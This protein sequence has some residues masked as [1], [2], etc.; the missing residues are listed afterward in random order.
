MARKPP[1]VIGHDDAD[2]LA[3][4]L[5]QAVDYDAKKA[6]GAVRRALQAQVKPHDKHVAKF[7]MLLQIAAA[8]R[9]DGARSD[10]DALLQVAKMACKS[11]ADARLLLRQLLRFKQPGQ[12]LARFAATQPFECVRTDDGLPEQ[13]RASRGGF[14]FK[15]ADHSERDRQDAALDVGLEDTFPASDA[16]AVTQPAPARYIGRVNNPS[17]SKT[18]Y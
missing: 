1:W 8:I 18:R 16:V 5:V 15:P 12:T 9:R 3:S 17:Y 7:Q 13:I 11:E 10:T 4:A 6:Y 2:Q 14:S